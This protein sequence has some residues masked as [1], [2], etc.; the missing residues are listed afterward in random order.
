MADLFL[1]PKVLDYKGDKYE[2][3][4]LTMR[5]ARTLKSRG[6]PE[7]MQ[8]LIEKSL[9][10]LVDNKITAA[11]ILAA[12]VPEAPKNEIPDVVSAIEDG[13]GSMK[14]APDDEE[15]TDKKKAKKKKKDE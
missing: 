13:P 15:D 11:E 7:P 5:W 12:P 9:S 3:I 1:H 4:R 14:L 6:T 2:L 10:D 8:S